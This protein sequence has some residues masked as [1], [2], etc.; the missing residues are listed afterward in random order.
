[1]IVYH[2]DSAPG[3]IQTIGQDFNPFLGQVLPSRTE[4]NLD[5]TG[6]QGAIL[7]ERPCLGCNFSGIRSHGSL[8]K[9]TGLTLGQPLELS[10]LSLLILH[11]LFVAFIVV[12]RKSSQRRR[13]PSRIGQP[14]LSAARMAVI[15]SRDDQEVQAV[16]LVSQRY[17]HSSAEGGSG[18]TP[19]SWVLNK[20]TP[21]AVLVVGAL[22]LMQAIPV[23]G[24]SILTMPSSGQMFHGASWKA[25]WP[26][27]HRCR[28]DLGATVSRTEGSVP[29]WN[30]S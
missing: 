5:G 25:S 29:I 6:D 24:V 2:S 4:P 27:L 7:G 23:A 10:L 8:M 19:L 22:I 28:R 26:W 13:D 3:V 18:P 21:V 30:G 20:T 12:E 1:M 17:S 14:V 15:L 9:P 16:L 11:L